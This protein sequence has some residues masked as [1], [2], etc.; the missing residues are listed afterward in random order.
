MKRSHAQKA[1]PVQRVREANTKP[2]DSPVP[3]EAPVTEGDRDIDPKAPCE[4]HQSP[5]VCVCPS[6]GRTEA[7][8][9]IT[10]CHEHICPLC[11][12]PMRQQ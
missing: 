4:S 5:G 10:P 6:C 12:I 1:D 11:G 8:V 9:S 2:A 3:G 7:R